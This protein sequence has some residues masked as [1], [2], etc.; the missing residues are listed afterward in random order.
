MSNQWSGTGPMQ[1]R[2]LFQCICLGISP[3]SFRT[4]ASFQGRAPAERVFEEAVQRDVRAAQE[5]DLAVEVGALGGR[6][7]AEFAHAEARRD[8][9][10][11]GAGVEH[12]EERVFGRPEPGVGILP[13][14][15]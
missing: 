15:G 7:E 12:I 2:K 10:P 11:A 4:Q 1:K 8:R 9:V 3:S 14:S 5:I 6:V 13:E